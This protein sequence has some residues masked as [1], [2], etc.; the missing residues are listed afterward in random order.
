MTACAAK[1]EK[2]VEA[3]K[4]ICAE[5]EVEDYGMITVALDGE[6]APETVENFVT[7]ANEGFYD[8]LTFHRIMEGFM[9]QGGDPSGNG[10]GGF[11]KNIKGEFEANGVDNP[12][13]HTRGAIR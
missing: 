1:E 2:I 7:L 3:T 12:L 4:K 13:S 11:G 8:G 9:M 5:I 6:A 10:T